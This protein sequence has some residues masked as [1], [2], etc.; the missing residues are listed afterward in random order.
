MWRR[1][2]CP[3]S[4]TGGQRK[5][6]IELVTK[7]F[8]L[9]GLQLHIQPFPS[10]EGDE[11]VALV[12]LRSTLCFC[13]RLRRIDFQKRVGVIAEQD[14]CPCD[15]VVERRR[16]LI[17]KSLIASFIFVPSRQKRDATLFSG[18]INGVAVLR[19]EVSINIGP[20]TLSVRL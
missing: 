10:G 14:L 1:W 20:G 18:G 15:V 2:L 12:I 13:V 7:H 19:H 4:H 9:A 6:L 8:G 17:K 11:L 16:L 5:S 3:G